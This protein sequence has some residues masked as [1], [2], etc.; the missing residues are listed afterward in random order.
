MVT[1]SGVE[2]EENQEQ[3]R[4]NPDHLAPPR[5]KI[6]NSV[7]DIDNPTE[8]EQRNGPFLIGGPGW[9][10]REQPQGKHVNQRPKPEI[11]REQDGGPAGRV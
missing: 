10:K 7:P 3:R 1:A 11:D 4:Q 8:N 2:D 9:D 5:A 6:E